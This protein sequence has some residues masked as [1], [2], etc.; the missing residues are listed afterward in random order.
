[1]SHNSE[2]AIRLSSTN[3]HENVDLDL[4]TVVFHKLSEP[5]RF[6]LL[7]TVSLLQSPPIAVPSSQSATFYLSRD[8][9]LNERSLEMPRES[10]TLFFQKEN[11]EKPARRYDE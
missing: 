11:V 4:I 2:S 10:E 9:S 1:M 3:I 8:G 7:Q 6:N 5:R